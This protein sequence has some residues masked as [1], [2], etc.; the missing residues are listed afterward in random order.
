MKSVCARMCV[1]RQTECP[2]QH[3]RRGMATDVPSVCLAGGGGVDKVSCMRVRVCVCN[4]RE[5]GDGIDV[6]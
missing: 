6:T 3:R 1:C 4:T 5:V 2:R